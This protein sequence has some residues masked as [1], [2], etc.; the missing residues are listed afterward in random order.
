[1]ACFA[2]NELRK[3]GWSDGKGLGKKEHG[4]KEAIKIKRKNNTSGLGLDIA[5][6]FT[7]HWWDHA[8]NKAA[9][10]IN[11]DTTGDEVKLSKT[12]SIEPLS[13]RKLTK[14]FNGKPL[15]YGS[16]VKAG[17]FV[18][19]TTNE[20]SDKKE[21]SS[22]SEDE[23][24][25][26]SKDTLERTYKIT[27]LTGHKAARHGHG[28]SGKLKRIL[29]Q[30]ESSPICTP[31]ASPEHTR[32]WDTQE[33]I[34]KK[35]KK[36]KK[37]TEVSNMNKEIEEIGSICTLSTRGS[38]T[39]E[40]IPKKKKKKKKHFEVSDMEEK[41]EEISSICT[42]IASSEPT[43]GSDTSK[44]IP[45][46]KK[47]HIEVSNMEEKKECIA[48]SDVSDITKKEKKKKTKTSRERTDGIEKDVDESSKYQY[49]V[50]QLKEKSK[51]KS[52]K[53]KL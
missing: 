40:P 36:K 12:E 2:T 38:D 4:I 22:S 28:M 10:S 11:V 29:D 9:K 5:E 52:K 51:T 6:Q 26:S 13:T 49:D 18:P 27:G 3:H 14:Y 35:K 39:C 43:R 23:V 44:T 37:N 20:K 53:Q 8:F 47:N 24:D 42:F 17:S 16:F 34:P 45:K 30:E 15:V 21:E 41:K 48:V 50:V 7:Y 25:Y 33:P 19:G 31:R 1:M 46:K 32:E